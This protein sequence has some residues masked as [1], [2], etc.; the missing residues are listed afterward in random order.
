MGALFLDSLEVEEVPKNQ[1]VSIAVRQIFIFPNISFF[2]GFVSLVGNLNV[3]QAYVLI[4]ST[5][6]GRGPFS[7]PS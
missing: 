1:L 7:C 2:L 4:K 5:G 3:G 6:N